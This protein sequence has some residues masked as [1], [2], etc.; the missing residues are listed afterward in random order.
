MIDEKK[1]E[2]GK[3]IDK[4]SKIIH[5]KKVEITETTV[6]GRRYEVLS[7]AREYNPPVPYVLKNE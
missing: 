2:Q 4:Y 3:Y 7:F 5:G 1:R 6:V